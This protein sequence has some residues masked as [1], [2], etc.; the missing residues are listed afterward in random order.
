FAS[1]FGIPVAAVFLLGAS[2]S[3]GLDR[4]TPAHAPRTEQ[5]EMPLEQW[6]T[7]G[8]QNLP[9]ARLD[10]RGRELQYFDL[11]WAGAHDAIEAQLRAAGWQPVEPATFTG[12]LRWF[13]S[14][15]PLANLPVLP[16]VHAGHHARLTL[17]LP[18]DDDHQRLVRLW[19]SGV[20]VA[21]DGT[22]V[23][24]WLGQIQ[25]QTAQTRYRL[26]RTPVS[27]PSTLA[28]PPLPAATPGT[29]IR[30][31]ERGGRRLWLMG[32]PSPLYTAPV[33]EPD[34]GTPVPL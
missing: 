29:A 15:T 26:F 2:M 33:S 13:A 5:G 9:A 14:T 34:P 22:S 19:D 23:P 28:L 20:L 18:L 8:W 16:Q 25:E 11:Q 3:W 4:A 17:R 1:S 30:S 6:W 32:P 7:S 31:A 24:V 21:R 10:V 27:V 12:A